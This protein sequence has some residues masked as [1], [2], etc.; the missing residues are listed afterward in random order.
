M[1]ET[2]HTFWRV[3]ADSP[4]DWTQC[5]DEHIVFHRASGETHYLNDLTALAL[6]MLEEKPS[7]TREL[8]IQLAGFLCISASEDFHQ[9]IDC[10]LSRLDQLG[11]VERSSKGTFAQ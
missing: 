2:S 8:S 1:M 9:Q 3:P 4:L 7:D 10:L 6:R 5:G 11:I